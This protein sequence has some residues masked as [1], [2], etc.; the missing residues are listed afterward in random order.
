MTEADDTTTVAAVP[1]STATEDLTRAL[2]TLEGEPA[3]V[4][5]TLV[6]EGWHSPDDVNALRNQAIAY[7]SLMWQLAIAVG[8][9]KD[10][11]EIIDVDNAEL[12]EQALSMIDVG[13]REA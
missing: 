4:A 7:N 12:V 11:D 10:G 3:V 8:W 13:M 2:S 9:A 1:E 6:D 5:A